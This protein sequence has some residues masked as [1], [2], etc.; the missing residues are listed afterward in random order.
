[1]TSRIRSIFVVAALAAMFA[2]PTGASAVATPVIL[3]G[4]GNTYSPLFTT[5]VAA[6]Q[7]GENIMYVQADATGLHDVVALAFGPDDADHCFKRTIAIPPLGTPYDP[8]SAPFLLDGQGNKIRAYQPGQCPMFTTALI[9]VG[10][11][12]PV[13]G[14]QNIVGGAIYEFK[15][16]IHSSMRGRL[17]GLP[18]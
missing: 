7:P 3:S 2:V 13:E 12:Y 10:H 9:S 11:Q 1:M 18:S 8:S 6:A 15:C 5:P 4:P 17:V 16:S 14:L